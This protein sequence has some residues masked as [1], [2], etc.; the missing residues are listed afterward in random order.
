MFFLFLGQATIIPWDFGISFSLF[1]ESSFLGFSQRWLLH[2][3]N[4][5]FSHL[6]L[7]FLYFSF[8]RMPDPR[9]H[10]ILSFLFTLSQHLE[11]CLTQ[12]GI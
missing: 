12:C 8:T 11:H 9:E 5:V 3:Y 4:L 2:I 10:K 1:M 7:Y 6:F